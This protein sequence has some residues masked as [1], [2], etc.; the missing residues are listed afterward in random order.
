ML[1]MTVFWG[2]GQHDSCEGDAA[3]SHESFDEFE[4]RNP[5]RVSTG[6]EESALPN[7]MK[8]VHQGGVFHHGFELVKGRRN[9]GF[10]TRFVGH[11]SGFIELNL[12]IDLA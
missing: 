2:A 10:E 7:S 6:M 3:L 11:G 1:R 12:A 9:A 4:V 5:G 8:G